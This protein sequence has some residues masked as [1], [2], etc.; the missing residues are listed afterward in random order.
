MFLLLQSKVIST[1]RVYVVLSGF[2]ISALTVL[3]I[4]SS[5]IRTTTYYSVHKEVL[6]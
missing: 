4:S 5:I 1:C 6:R 3:A 2:R